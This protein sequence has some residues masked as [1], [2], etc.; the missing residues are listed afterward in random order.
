MHGTIH[1]IFL[2]KIHFHLTYF[3]TK[4][5]HYKINFLMIE[6]KVDSLAFELELQKYRQFSTKF[7]MEV[8]H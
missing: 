5:K 1:Q 6:P 7:E 8:S 4:M 2:E 3:R